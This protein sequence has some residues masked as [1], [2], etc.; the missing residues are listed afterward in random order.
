MPSTCN[1]WCDTV[2]LTAAPAIR[3]PSRSHTCWP[4]GCEACCAASAASSPPR[5]PGPPTPNAPRSTICS[6]MRALQGGQQEAG[7]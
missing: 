1:K 3:F 2:T 7:T 4:S 5:E 6:L